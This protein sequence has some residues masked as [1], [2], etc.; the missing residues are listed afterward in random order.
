MTKDVAWNPSKY[1]SAPSVDEDWFAAFTDYTLEPTVG[2]CS[3]AWHNSLLSDTELLR[4]PNNISVFGAKS[5][6]IPR[7]Y[8]SLRPYFLG[9]P[10][11]VVRLTYA[12]TTQY[13]SNYSASGHV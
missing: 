1:N 5:T 7:D 12:A 10:S 11:D 6:L 13:Y 9:M 4:D 2:T 8:E 3:S